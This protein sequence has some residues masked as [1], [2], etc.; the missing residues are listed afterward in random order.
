MSKGRGFTTVK[1]KQT[2]VLGEDSFVAES[3]LSTAS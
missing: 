3:A 2:A 1:V